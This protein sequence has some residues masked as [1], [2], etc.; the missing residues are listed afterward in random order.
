[1]AASVGEWGLFTF[2][3]PRDEQIT[4]PNR[5]VLYGDIVTLK[6]VY[7][8]QY[9]GADLDMPGNPLTARVPSIRAWQKFD[10]LRI[11]EKQEQLDGRLRHGSQFVLRA[12]TGKFVMYDRDTS[13]QLLCVVEEA[14]LWECFTLHHIRE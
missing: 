10:L 13:K 12:C 2:V 3:Y 8:E 5:P 14:S 11:P 7:N 9:I 4:K 6:S 1:M